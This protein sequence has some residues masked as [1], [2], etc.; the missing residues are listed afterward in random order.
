M[1]L[2]M[3]SRGR[4]GRSATRRRPR[5]GSLSSFPAPTMAPGGFAPRTWR[6][7]VCRGCRAELGPHRH[8][9]G[10]RAGCRARDADAQPGIP[11]RVRAR[12]SLLSTTHGSASS[13]STSTAGGARLPD[14]EHDGTSRG[15]RRR[16]EAKAGNVAML[17]AFPFFD[18]VLCAS[19]FSSSCRASASR[20]RG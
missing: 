9:R 13:G 1:K 4:L 14:A 12:S 18:P 11:V 19:R 8:A 10:D 7:W 16:L 3:P 20:H 5:A 15:Q 6:V 2:P 17:Q